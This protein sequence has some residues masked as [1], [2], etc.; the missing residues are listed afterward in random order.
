[1]SKVATA[2]APG[3]MF[4]LLILD[5]YLLRQFL[6][7]FLICFISLMGLYVVIDGFAN[8]EEFIEYGRDHGGLLKVIAAYYGPR[9]LSFLDSMGPI[10]TLTAAM[11]TVT[12]I[13]RHQELTAIEAAGVP[14]ARVIRPIISAAI[15]ISLFNALVNREAVIP[16]YRH[17]L[18][19]NAQDLGGSSGKALIPRYDNETDILLGG[20]GAKTYANEQR[21]FHPDFYLP[22][23]LDRHGT[24]VAAENAYYQPPQVG[25]PG[26]YLFRD[27][28]FP[29]GLDA[30]PTLELD[31]RPI[32]LTPQDHDWLKPNECF[33]ASN[34]SFEHLE[35]GAAWRQYSSTY[36]LIGGLRNRSLDFGADERMAI[37]SRFVQPLLDVTLLFL[38]LPLILSR[39]NRN[40]YFAIGMCVLLVTAFMSV[41]MG[42]KYLGSS[43]WL[44]PASAAWLPLMVFVPCA[45]ALSGP[46]RE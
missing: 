33:V 15:I 28:E 12:W 24:R 6:Q 10:L 21:I 37:H 19:H 8:L 22:P 23:G 31:R 45:V 26:G 29:K 13:Q 40:V 17:E 42:C 44:E 4:R 30:R 32:L 7:T 46:L 2:T 9:S 25:R 35:G 43:Y 3:G 18:S 41:V 1:V 20:S 14:K 38:G 36:G 34:V 16:Q 27:V 11:F 39:S 5:R